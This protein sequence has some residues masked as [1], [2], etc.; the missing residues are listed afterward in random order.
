VIPRPDLHGVYHVATRPI[1]K[2]DLLRLVAERY[3][4]KIELI[5]D[6]RASPDRSLIAARFAKATGYTAP[7]WPALVDLMY[8]DRFAAARA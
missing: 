5:P 7:D 3:G 8:R 6:D 2:F 4:K 1:S